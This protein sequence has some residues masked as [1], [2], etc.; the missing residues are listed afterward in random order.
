MVVLVVRV[1]SGI[2]GV[3]VGAYGPVRRGRVLFGGDIMVGVFIYS[4]DRIKASLV[5]YFFICATIGDV[6]R[7]FYRIYA[8]T[9]RLRFLAYLDY[10]CATTS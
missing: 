6:G 5:L 1:L 10:E 3:C 9:R 4:E 8:D 7:T 2:R